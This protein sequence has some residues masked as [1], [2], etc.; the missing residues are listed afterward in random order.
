[1]KTLKR[2]KQ[3]VWHNF[4]ANKGGDEESKKTN[5]SLENKTHKQRQ[6]RRREPREKQTYRKY[7]VTSWNQNYNTSNPNKYKWTKFANLLRSYS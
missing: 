1:M 7:T 3:G 5:N 6:E 2:Q 4:Q